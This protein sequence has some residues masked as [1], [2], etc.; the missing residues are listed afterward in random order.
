MSLNS[1]CLSSSSRSKTCLTVIP[2]PFRDLVSPGTGLS[3]SES[4]GG[5]FLCRRLMYEY[6]IIRSHAHGSAP[7]AR[8]PFSRNPPVPTSVAG[9]A[10]SHPEVVS[11]ASPAPVTSFHTLPTRPSAAG[12][13]QSLRDKSVGLCLSP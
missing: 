8:A 12:K 2:S 5:V 4:L 7:V 13:A 3:S 11:S 6:C 1:G 10:E 9:K